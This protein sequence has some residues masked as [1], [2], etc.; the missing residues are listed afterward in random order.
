METWEFMNCIMEAMGCQRTR[1]DLPAKMLLSAALFS[2]MIRYRLGFQMFS[3]P[4]L[5]PDTIYF[6]SCTRTFNTSKARRLLGY[7]A[8]VSLEDGIMRI[9]GHLQNYQIIWV[10]RGNNAPVDHRKQISC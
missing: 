9:S 8:I 1:I 4:L 2:N 3:T 6:L 10:S 7:Y 5:H